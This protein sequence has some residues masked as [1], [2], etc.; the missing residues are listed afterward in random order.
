VSAPLPIEVSALAVAHERTAETWW[1]L[2]RP[3]AP[4]ARQRG[5]P[6]RQIAAQEFD[7]GLTP[8]SYR[9]SSRRRLPFSLPLAL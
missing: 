5:K 9:S 4:G 6:A 3:K 2:N 7:A 1:G 8:F